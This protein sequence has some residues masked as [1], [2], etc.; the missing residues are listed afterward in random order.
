MNFE[1]FWLAEYF[2]GKEGA[3]VAVLS[4]GRI[5]GGD[6]QFFYSGSYIQNGDRIEGQVK[7][8]YHH[9]SGESIFG[10]DPDNYFIP[11]LSGVLVERS[12]TP[13]LLITGSWTDGREVAIRLTVIEPLEGT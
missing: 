2:A 11:S 3:G 5:H 10:G 7:V 9:G 4:N 12:K 1:G 13:V 8:V 6:G